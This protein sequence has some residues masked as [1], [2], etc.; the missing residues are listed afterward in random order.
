DQLENALYCAKIACYAQGFQLMA[1]AAKDRGWTL[2]FAEIAKI[3]RAG[4]IIRARFLQS[5]TQAYQ[6]AAN[7]GTELDNLLM[8]VDFSIALSEKQLDWRKAVSAAVLKGIPV[9]CISSA[10][11]YYDS[12]RCETLP[13][14]LLQGQRDFFGAHTFERTDK[15][16]GEKYHLNR[17]HATR[18]LIKV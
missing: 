3:W 12:Y 5:I 6:A 10:L 14:S 16:A 17:S 8:A 11:A 1:M 15:P 9:P 13:A 4:C 7:D 18:D 2:N